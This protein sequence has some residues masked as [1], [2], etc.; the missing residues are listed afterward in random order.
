MIEV[1]RSR[2]RTTLKLGLFAGDQVEEQPAKKE[3]GLP[4]CRKLRLTP[5]PAI[6]MTADLNDSISILQK[7]DNH[8]LLDI[9]ILRPQ[10]NLERR[11]TTQGEKAIEDIG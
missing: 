3:V 11:L 1:F 7:L 9:K 5:F 6:L 4:V 8:V 2:G 10:R